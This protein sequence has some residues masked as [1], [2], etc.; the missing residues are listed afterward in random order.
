VDWNTWIPLLSFGGTLLLVLTGL[1][2][3]SV[4]TRQLRAAREQL[5]TARQQ[6]ESAQQQP[7]IQ[8]IQ[9]AI[10]ETT[11]HLRIFVERPYLRPYFYE[12][13]RWQEGDRASLDEVRAMAE[14]L[15]N[16]FASSI[17]HSA[18]FQQYPLGSVAQTIQF[19]LRNSAVLQH[20]L[21]DN[22][23]RFPLSGLTLI[24]FMSDSRANTEARLRQ[25]IETAGDDPKEQQRRRELLAYYQA[26]G[27]AEPLEFAKHA[28]QLIRAR[29][30]KLTLGA[31]TTTFTPSR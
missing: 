11:D 13:Q 8:L 12:D 24:A 2:N 16:I 6:L 5:D 30:P 14:L 9:R 31:S 22:F 19:H 21:Q 23:D 1:L 28:L 29:Q 27:E 25:L 15:L 17:I 4:F 10:A 3:F 26:A 7:E 18:A 20:Y